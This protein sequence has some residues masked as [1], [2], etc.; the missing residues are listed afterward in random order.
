MGLNDVPEEF[1]EIL[2]VADDHVVLNDK[3][4][5]SEKINNKNLLPKLTAV[6]HLK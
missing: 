5:T 6:S 4:I 3:K 1:F 2:I